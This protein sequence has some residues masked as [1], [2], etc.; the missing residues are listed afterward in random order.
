MLFALSLERKIDHHDG[1]LLHNPDQKNDPYQGHHRQVIP[2]DHERENRSHSRGRQRRKDRD[3]M[4]VALV[5]HAQH[6]IHRND[7]RQDQIRLR[8][9]RVLK[10]CRRPLK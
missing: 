10:R 2:R 5:Q 9:Q 4:D 3:G 8:G 6:D 1:V 7:R